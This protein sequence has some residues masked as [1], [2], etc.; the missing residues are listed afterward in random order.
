MRVC[1]CSVIAERAQSK[2][3]P[4]CGQCDSHVP[5]QLGNGG[6]IGSAASVMSSAFR[7]SQHPEPTPTP[8][9]AASAGAAVLPAQLVLTRPPDVSLD[10][11]LRVLGL[12]GSDSAAILL[13]VMAQSQHWAFRI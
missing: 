11:L 10:D 9:V 2:G 12:P 1:T 4:Q 13:R 7:P 5:Q 3:A 8:A 6:A